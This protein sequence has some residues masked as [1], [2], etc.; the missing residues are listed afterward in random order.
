MD[1]GRFTDGTFDDEL[2]DDVLGF[3]DELEPDETEGFVTELDEPDELVEPDG[4]FTELPELPDEPD[5]LDEPE[6]AELLPTV[7]LTS[8]TISSDVISNSLLLP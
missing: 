5:E 1:A 6:P 4:L 8:S 2:D 7:C 3:F